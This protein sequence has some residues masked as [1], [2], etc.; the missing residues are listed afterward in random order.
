[1]SSANKDGFASSFPIGIPFIF[2]YRWNLKTWGRMKSEERIE[3]H[4][5][6]SR[7]YSP[8]VHHYLEMVEKEK[9]IQETRKEQPVK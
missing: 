5:Q 1:M 6:Q 4:G 7:G 3:R 9:P 2:G 8:E